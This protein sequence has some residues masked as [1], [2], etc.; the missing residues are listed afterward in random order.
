MAEA[1]IWWLILQLLASFSLV[2]ALLLFRTLP[3][4]GYGFAKALG[5]LVPAYA[6]WLLAWTGFLPNSRATVFGVV[7][8]A[9]VASAY[10]AIRKRLVRPLW[11]FLRENWRVVLATETVFAAAFFAFALLRAYHPDIAGTEQPMDFGFLNS[12]L[13]ST[14]FP[15]NDPWLSGHSIT[16]YYFG[17]IIQTLPI[18]IAA[19]PSGIGYNLALATILAM[20][21]TGAFSLG[22]NLVAPRSSK[23]AVLVGA[24]AAVLVAAIGNLEGLLEIVRSWGLGTPAFWQWIGINGVLAPAAST[25]VLPTDHFWWWHA[26]RVI[27]TLRITTGPDGSVM[28][29]DDSADYT[30]TEFPAFSFILGDMHPHVMA[31][32]YAMLALGLALSFLRRGQAMGL[33]WIRKEPFGFVGAALVLGAIGFIN[34]WDF[35]IYLAVP[36]GAMLLGAARSGRIGWTVL[37]TMAA[38][39]VASILLYFPFYVGPKPSVQGPGL[40]GAAGTSPVHFFIVWGTFM[41]ALGS[42]LAPRMPAAGREAWTRPRL[43]FLSLTVAMAPVVLWA[44]GQAAVQRVFGLPGVSGATALGKELSVAPLVLTVA[45]VLFLLL[46]PR[47]RGGLEES[48]VLMLALAG[49]ALTLGTELFFLR[50]A[51]GNRMNSMFKFYYQAWVLFAIA[52]AYGIYWVTVRLR[53]SVRMARLGPLWV[54]G[55][56]VLLISALA[57]PVAA[58]Y[59]RMDMFKKEPSLDGLAFLKRL[60]PAEY[61]AIN[62]INNNIEAS[63]VIVEAPGNSYTDYGR[64]SSSTGLP[65]VVEWPGHQIQWRGSIK[66]LG[67]REQDV[68]LIYSSADMPLVQSL[69]GKYGIRYVYVG[70]LERSKYGDA[71]SNRFSGMM[72]VAFQNQGVTIFRVRS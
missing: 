46:S 60:D 22:Y 52:S 49:F 28:A 19:I 70:R 36:L 23:A 71:V 20:T 11:A 67:E 15:P 6:L 45:F 62:W 33:D 63:P 8:L 58:S 68:N 42:F 16:Y 1:L 17:Y 4:R 31:L 41:F 21:V 38:L 30:I 59:N 9:G 39:G 34:S 3:D 35:P 61:Q 64:I 69:I 25:S 37:G 18:Q 29:V 50:D 47:L 51:F 14:Y 66:E 53:A 56:A 65:A 57:Y 43:A 26:T 24:L 5:L 44:L 27:N 55:M 12:S 32:P 54:A 40:V 48:F 2:P 13:R 72:D 10:V 7:L